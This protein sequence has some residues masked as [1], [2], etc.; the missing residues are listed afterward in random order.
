MMSMLRLPPDFMLIV[1]LTNVT[2]SVMPSGISSNRKP[3]G[4]PAPLSRH[5]SRRPH[6]F[7][8][9]WPGR[10]MSHAP[11]FDRLTLSLP[12]DGTNGVTIDAAATGDPDRS[13]MVID[14]PFRSFT[15]FSFSS[16]PLKQFVDV[17]GSESEDLCNKITPK[18]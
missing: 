8:V 17:L 6:G 15:G 12:G 10:R 2:V 14:H 11:G 4:S 1:E 5:A 9:P 7:Q 3:R 16:V 18:Y 13:W